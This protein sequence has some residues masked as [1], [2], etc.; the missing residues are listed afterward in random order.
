MITAPVCMCC[1]HTYTDF[2]ALGKQL[3]TDN[4]KTFLDLG[5]IFPYQLAGSM[6]GALRDGF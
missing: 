5:I 2:K 4:E 3:V 1:V 6:E